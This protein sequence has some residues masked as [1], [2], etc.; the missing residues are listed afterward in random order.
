MIAP[1]SYRIFATCNIP[2][3]QHKLARNEQLLYAAKVC[4]ICNFLILSHLIAW[5]LIIICNNPLTRFWALLDT[6]KTK[7]NL[8]HRDRKKPLSSAYLL[9]FAIFHKREFLVCVYY[10]GDI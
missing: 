9:A 1:N 3:Q 5:Y 7:S 4:Q 10:D 8:V 2:S 6:N